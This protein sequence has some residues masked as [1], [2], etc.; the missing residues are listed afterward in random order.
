VPEAAALAAVQRTHGCGVAEAKAMLAAFRRDAT[1]ARCA[2]WN[3]LMAYC[4][5]SAAPAGRFLLRLHGEDRAADAP[6]DALCAALQ[7]LNHLSDMAAD[8]DR[9]GRVYLPV[10][11]TDAAGGEAAVFRPDGAAAR[12]ALTDAALDRVDHLLDAAEAMPRLLAD[13]RLAAQ[14]AATVTVARR[15][16]RRLRAADPLA[17]RIRPGVADAL[18]GLVAGL[19]AGVFPPVAVALGFGAYAGARL[20]WDDL[21]EAAPEPAPP[22]RAAIEPGPLDEAAAR[23]LAVRAAAPRLPL[24][25]ALTGAVDAMEALRAEL[26]PRPDMLPEARRF[27]LTNLDGIERIQARLAAGAE[28]PAPLSPLLAE[29]ARAAD[30]WRGRL[31]A[32][33]TEALEIQVKVM[34]DRLR[35]EG[36]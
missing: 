16:A 17:T 7:I 36:R 11:W 29:M 19:G 12:R 1:G 25:L 3:D 23:L 24:T 15:H 2:D 35:E 31:R 28:P 26:A 4:A 33:E 32:L 30:D 6:A 18:A 10:A 34:A 27:L 22:P 14:A 13:R 8:R 5:L 21:P 9:L 20:I